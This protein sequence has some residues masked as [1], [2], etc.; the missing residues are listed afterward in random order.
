MLL[1]WTHHVSGDWN[2]AANW[3]TT[4]PTYTAASAPP[5]DGDS[6]ALGTGIT[7]YPFIMGGET[8]DL[9]SGVCSVP[10]IAN[11]GTIAGGTFTGAGFLMNVAGFY[12]GAITG[13]V[14]TGLRTCVPLDAGAP[15]RP[16]CR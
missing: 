6:C 10:N 4:D 8:V 15:A 7:T 14:F 2:T 16:R 9:G 5:G 12:F 3:S 13:G 11:G 1:Y